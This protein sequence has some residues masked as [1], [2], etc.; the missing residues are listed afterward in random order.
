M[1][2]FDAVEIIEVVDHHPDR[3]LQPLVAQIRRPVDCMQAGPI[4]QV[5]A[6]NGVQCQMLR[7][8]FDE[9]PRTECE[10][11]FPTWVGGIGPMHFGQ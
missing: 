11:G 9:V 3:L 5:K 1:I 6:R 4:A 2:F 10:G 8:F 7:A